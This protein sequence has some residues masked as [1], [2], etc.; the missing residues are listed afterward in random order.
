M[1]K[2]VHIVTESTADLPIELAQEHDIKVIP[3]SVE[4]AGATYQDGVTITPEELYQ[5]M[6]EEKVTPTTTQITPAQYM[7]VFREI[8]ESGQ[9]PVYIGFSSKL[10]GSF[11]SSVVAAGSFA[12]NEVYVLDTKAASLG[13]GLLALEAAKMASQGAEPQEIVSTIGAKAKT[14]EHLVVVDT[15]EYLA[16]GGRISNAK[17]F[18]GNILNLKPLIHVVD[19]ALI[20]FETA[21]TRK[22]ALR[23]LVTLME[24]RGVDIQNQTVGI[25]HADNLQTATELKD[26]IAERFGTKEFIISTI[27][28]TIGAHAGPGTVA[29]FFYGVRQGGPGA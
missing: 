5:R 6:R 9:I 7:Q 4:I 19:G 28:A 22:K 12:E 26:L 23:R 8:I 20:P 14:L 25:S 21:R 17:A 18:L 13:E 1:T 3:M 27:G 15:L 10:S 16:R 24:E 29:V 11:Q 2:R